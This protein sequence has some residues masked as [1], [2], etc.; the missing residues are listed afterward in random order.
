MLNARDLCGFPATISIYPV[1]SLVNFL[2]FVHFLHQVFPVLYQRRFFDRVPALSCLGRDLP[3]LLCCLLEPFHHVVGDVSYNHLAHHFGYSKLKFDIMMISLLSPNVIQPPDFFLPH[4]LIQC[5]QEL[6][7]VFVMKTTC[8]SLC[9]RRFRAGAGSIHAWRWPCRCLS[10]R[11]L[12][13][14]GLRTSAAFF[15]T[16][17]GERDIGGN[18]DV[19]GFVVLSAI[20][21]SATSAPCADND[22]FH[23]RIT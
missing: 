12:C 1:Q 21:S 17:L 5:T 13:R 7:A 18:Y 6:R 10:G 23:H 2:Q 4:R 16:A 3:A 22:G 8:Y 15:E 11:R 14:S 19:A 20:Q 9:S